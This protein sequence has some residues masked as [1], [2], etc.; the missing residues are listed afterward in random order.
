MPDNRLTIIPAH[1]DAS[2]C[3]LRYRE[4]GSIVHSWHVIIAWA[5]RLDLTCT[6]PIPLTASGWPTGHCLDAIKDNS[7]LILGNLKFGNVHELIAAIH[8]GEVPFDR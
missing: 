5:I 3:R 7:N 1:P 6:P 8:S 4:D 2:L